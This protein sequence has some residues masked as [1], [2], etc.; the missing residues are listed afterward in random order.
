MPNH[1]L[2]L[3][4]V[5][6]AAVA[7]KPA[8]PASDYDVEP[9][10]PPSPAPVRQSA[11]DGNVERPRPTPHV[12]PYMESVNQAHAQRQTNTAAAEQAHQ[13]RMAADKARRDQQMQQDMGKVQ[14]VRN[15]MDEVRTEHVG[16]MAAMHQRLDNA[17]TAIDE[18]QTGAPRSQ[19]LNIGADRENVQAARA[20]APEMVRQERAAEAARRPQSVSDLERTYKQWGAGDAWRHAGSMGLNQQDVVS[21]LVDMAGRTTRADN[22]AFLGQAQ[23]RL[24]DLQR[25]SKTPGAARPKSRVSRNQRLRQFSDQHSADKSPLASSYRRWGLR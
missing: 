25:W 24:R 19:R 6:V 18:H 17:N 23:S 2:G 3:W 14:G 4:Y 13:Q 16:E 11:F 9:P 8:A 1:V 7:P 10:A 5:K 12:N 15:R 20:A 21:P 22:Q